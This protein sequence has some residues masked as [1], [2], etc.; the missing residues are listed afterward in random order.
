MS[1]FSYPEALNAIERVARDYVKKM[2]PGRNV[3]VKVNA[4]TVT[5]TASVMWSGVDQAGADIFITI[6][7]PV[8]PAAYRMTTG[9]FDHW[10]A[11]MLHELGHPKWTSLKVW[12]AAV[13]RR[14]HNL[15]NALE[16]V[17][18]EKATIDAGYARNAKDAFSA[19]VASIHAKAIVEGY[20]PNDV[21]SIGWT[22][23]T[24]GRHANG[25]DVDV[26]DI[27]GR[28]DPKG[29]V[30]AIVGWA[31]PDLAKCK[32]TQDC[33]DL[34][35]R[36]TAITNKLEKAKAQPK[37]GEGRGK[38]QS[39]GTGG[40][41]GQGSAPTADKRGDELFDDVDLKPNDSEVLPPTGKQYGMEKRLTDLLRIGGTSTRTRPIT[42]R[43]IGNSA[44]VIA[45]EA[46]KMGK[47][48]QLLARALKREEIDDYEGGRLS[49]RLDRRVLPRIAA[50]NPHIFGKRI[51]A[52]G[53]D[54]DV[55]ILIDGSSSMNGR[56]AQAAVTLGLVVAQA[57][58]Q[59]GVN[60]HACLFTDSGLQEITKGRYKPD[61]KKFA[62]AYRGTQGGTPLTANLIKVALEQAKRA[63]GKRRIIF[64]ITDG[65]CDIG[66]HAT[67]AAAT[68]IE[69]TL[70]A[71][72]AGMHIGMQPLG[73]YRNEVAVNVNNITA[74]GLRSL[75]NVLEK[76]RI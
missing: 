39:G 22:L 40:Q 76:G 74:T 60:C 49:G 23:S 18:E 48:R 34:A 59:V 26:D 56:N 13:A 63:P 8:K 16:D 11:Y 32:S 57:C 46:S 44:E 47:Q 58:S 37:E 41:Q 38:Q 73:I 9:E 35:D 43:D 6:H 14:A 1:M 64:S 21:R 66:S 12:E 33:L 51:S 17:R 75:T 42:G 20:D 30:A 62:W 72:I 52:E 3:Y 55:E 24:L 67:K 31:I 53:Y 69:N 4:D 10:A 50:G 27:H 7:M 15:L 71:E 19:L 68:Y 61:P 2:F 5:G 29:T 36:I 54:T 25:Y 65:G 70:G 45:G 28:L